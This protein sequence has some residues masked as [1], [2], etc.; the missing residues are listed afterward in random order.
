MSQKPV[1]DYIFTLLL[2]L[3]VYAEKCMLSLFLYVFLS[4]IDLKHEMAELEK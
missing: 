2:T 4:P 3:N 1:C